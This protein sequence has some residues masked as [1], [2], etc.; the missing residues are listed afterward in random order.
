VT[1]FR[2]NNRVIPYAPLDTVR[3]QNA[4][5]EKWSSLTFK[6]NRPAKL[7]LSNGGGS[8]MRDINRTFEISGVAGGKRAFYYDADTVNQVLYLQDKVRLAGNREDRAESGDGSRKKAKKKEQPDNWISKAALV[9]IGNEDTKIEP[10]AWSTR[11]TRGIVEESRPV[12][13]NRMILTYSTTDGSH[14]ILSG[15][16][17]KKDSIYVVLDRVNRKYALSESSL[18]AGKY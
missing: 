18:Q 12:K 16:D 1:E 9:N 14:V 10:I 7:D 4:T 13:R 11:R 8:P 5:F 2:I 6:V 3:W 17:E 15:I